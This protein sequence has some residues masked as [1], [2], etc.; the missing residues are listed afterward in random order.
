MLIRHRITKQAN[1]S[2]FSS[3]FFFSLETLIRKACSVRPRSADVVQGRLVLNE[4]VDFLGDV[5]DD[6]NP[7][8]QYQGDKES[9]Y[10]FL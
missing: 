3:S 5:E 10:E 4:T 8:N 7:D 2:R 6:Y 9:Q 1:N